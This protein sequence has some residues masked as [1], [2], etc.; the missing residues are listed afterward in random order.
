MSRV[1]HARQGGE[2]ERFMGSHC[3]PFGNDLGQIAGG[4]TV[5]FEGEADD[6]GGLGCWDEGDRKG[7]RQKQKRRQT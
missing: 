3:F 2:G 6:I 7:Q 4:E 1:A 5:V